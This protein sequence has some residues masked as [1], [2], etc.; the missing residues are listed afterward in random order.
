MTVPQSSRRSGFSLRL[1]QGAGRL[2][3]HERRVADTLDVERLHLSL[4]SV[5]AR[6]DMSTGVER[7]RHHRT[8]LDELVVSAE[9]QD[10]GRL[11]RARAADAPFVDLEV[12]ALTGHLAIAGT[13]QGRPPVPFIARAALEPA[14]IAT[15]RSILISVFDVRVLGPARWSGPEVAAAL[16]R[17]LGL[18][19]SL[20]GPTA[21]VLDPVQRILLEVFAELGWKL[22][23][24][25]EARI[26]TIDA[27]AGRVRLAA[28]RRESGRQGPRAVVPGRSPEAAALYRRFLADYEA[29]SLYGALEGRV[30][31]GA[32]EQAIAGYERQL[33]VHPDHPFVVRRLLQLM[34]ARPEARSECIGLA[35]AHLAR[36]PDDPD[37]LTA[38]ATA[39][40]AGGEREVAVDLWRRLADQAEARGDVL[41]AAQAL[42]AASVALDE[43]EPEGSIRALE[44]AL[45][46]RRRLPS[47]LRALAELHER[48][49]DWSAALRARER[50][51]AQTAD[52]EQR[53]TLLHEIG[54]L[55]LER[56]GEPDAASGYFERLLEGRPEDVDALLG[57]A[58]AHVECGRTLPAVRALDRAARLMQ[59]RGEAAGAAAILV[60]LGDLWRGLEDGG[61]QTAALRYRQALMLQPDH[62]GALLGLAEAA[63]GDGDPQRAREHLEA[64]LRL[65]ARESK[66]DRAALHLRLGGLVAGPLRDAAGAIPHYQK[67][68]DGSPETAAAALRALEDVYDEAERWDDLARVLEVRVQRAPD[69]AAR[70]AAMARLA[71]V[72]GGRLGAAG[73]ARGLLETAARL[74]PG[75][76]AIL[77]QL[78]E[79]LRAQDD[80]AGLVDALERWARGISVPAEEARA[81]AERGDLLRLRLNRVDD[82][83]AAYA[84]ALGCDPNHPGALEGLADIYRERERFAE[85][86]PILRRQ[87]EGDP[88][89]LGAARRWA[90]LG[91]LEARI[92]ERPPAGIVHLERAV[93]LDPADTR[94]LRLLRGRGVRRAAGAVPGAAR[95]RARRRGAC[96]RGGRGARCGPRARPGSTGGLRAGPGPAPP[97]RRYRGHRGVHARRPGA[98]EAIR[99]ARVPR[100]PGGAAAVARAPAAGGCRR[101]PGRRG[102]RGRRSRRHQTRGCDGAQRL[103]DGRVTPQ[104]AA[105]SGGW[106]RAAR[107]PD[108]P[109]AARLRG[110]GAAG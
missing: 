4:L 101:G 27:E 24:R 63:V 6:L 90:E 12:R 14:A 46:L 25:T 29:K 89:P 38:L 99:D 94:S 43:A 67:A 32:V 3:L 58:R 36:Y 107:D 96:G 48:L 51:L 91:L 71:H 49:G 75:D 82:A 77:G 61:P 109:R 108:P 105:L 10:L 72:I 55:A 98:R 9:D 66:L 53:R 54:A 65:P 34:S 106:R 2:V 26:D 39:H 85:L 59:D 84:R 37:A 74:Q 5:P 56:A 64:A 95:R 86:V 15:D 45:A 7:F 87:A 1:E 57:L 69:D 40:Q 20:H 21:A 104:G 8:A 88:D 41:E 100:T 83:A 31:D 18:E 80:P 97:E 17:L 16:L 33:E 110:A 68:L 47:A 13:L 92:L 22:P 76:S 23:D 52:A 78:V 102:R 60:Q 42:L 50:L 11:L 28:A 81:H 44:R 30:L 35:R 62:P 93:E 103:A 19:E 79:L 73:R 70:A